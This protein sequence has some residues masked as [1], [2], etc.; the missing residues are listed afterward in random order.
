MTDFVME[1]NHELIRKAFWTEMIEGLSKVEVRSDVQC[2]LSRMD[3]IALRN[4]R[5]HLLYSKERASQQKGYH[6]RELERLRREYVN[7]S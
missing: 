4:I 5:K 6:D 3:K 2:E 7:E 1:Y